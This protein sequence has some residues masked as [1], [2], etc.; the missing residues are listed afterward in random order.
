MAYS[1]ELFELDDFGVSV[2]RPHSYPVHVP[3]VHIVLQHATHD[4]FVERLLDPPAL[5]HD[6]RR[7]LNGIA[8][9]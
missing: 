9:T 1:L 3:Q 6:R 2:L 8:A 5:I 7:P 4:L